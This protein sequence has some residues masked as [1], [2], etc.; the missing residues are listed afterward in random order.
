MAVQQ[1]EIIIGIV[2]RIISP[3]GGTQDGITMTTRA[4]DV[5]AAIVGG[6]IVGVG[7][8]EGRENCQQTDN[9][10]NCSLYHGD[11]LTIVPGH[12]GTI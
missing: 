11:I 6:V 7:R 3:K 8:E 5:A 12:T 1:A 2:I 9:G 4:R 10:G